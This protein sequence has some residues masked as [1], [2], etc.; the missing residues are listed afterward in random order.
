MYFR[1]KDVQKFLK[2]ASLEK[3]LQFHGSR[4]SYTVPLHVPTASPTACRA[5]NRLHPA[6]YFAS[7]CSIRELLCEFRK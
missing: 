7:V 4:G 5:V 3:I 2:E 6:V 1:Y